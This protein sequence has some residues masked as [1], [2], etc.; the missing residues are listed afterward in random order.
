MGIGSDLSDLLTREIHDPQRSVS[1][2]A[3]RLAIQEFFSAIADNHVLGTRVVPGDCRN[4][5]STS[6]FA[7]AEMCCRRKS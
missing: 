7:A 4:P 6:P 5:P 3:R 1:L 2:L